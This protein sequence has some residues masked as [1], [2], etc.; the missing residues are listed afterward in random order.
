MFTGN[1]P[2]GHVQVFARLGWLGL[3]TQPAVC[4]SHMGV[5]KYLNLFAPFH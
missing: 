5:R 3:D 4:S 2:V 1:L